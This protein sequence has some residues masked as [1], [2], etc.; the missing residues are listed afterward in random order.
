MKSVQ[1]VQMTVETVRT[2]EGVF[3]A[4]SDRPCA[5]NLAS[6]N[7]RL[8]MR[9]RGIVTEDRNHDVFSQKECY[10]SCQTTFMQCYR[11]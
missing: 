5:E 4:N 2:K 9:L 11:H 10:L 6:T 7:V 8:E 1:C 3:D